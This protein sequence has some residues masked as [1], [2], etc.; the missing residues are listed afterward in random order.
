MK[1]LL[2]VTRSDWCF[3]RRSMKE[4]KAA[5]FEILCEVM[6][7]VLS[8]KSWSPTDDQHREYKIWLNRQYEEIA[9]IQNVQNAYKIFADKKELKILIII[10][11][12]LL[13]K[14]ISSNNLDASKNILLFK[15]P[16][17]HPAFLKKKIQVAHQ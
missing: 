14:I 4:K 12:N 15:L 3:P 13:T 9:K 8:D 10:I 5:K 1:K 17:F 2:S 6:Q 16:L 7:D 11:Q